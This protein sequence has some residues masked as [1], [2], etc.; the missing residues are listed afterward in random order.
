MKYL[1]GI[2]ESDPVAGV[3]AALERFERRCNVI[4]T[5]HDCCGTFCFP[6]GKSFFP[7]R[8]I[9]RHDYCIRGRFE[10]SGWNR[11]CHEDC[12]LGADAIARRSG[13]P[14]FHS[15]WKGCSEV[16]VPLRQ[17]GNP[18]LI[19]YAG[20]F[21]SEEVSP[22]EELPAELLELHGTLPV[23]DGEFREELAAELQLLGQGMLAL[24]GSLAPHSG[25][26]DY[27]RPE[28]IR[29]FITRHAHEEISLRE[30]A[31]F[32]HLSET[33][34]C[35]QVKYHFGVP[36]QR[37]LVEERMRRARNLLANTDKPLKMIALDTGLRN[38]FYFSRIF[39]RENGMP[40][41]RY[42]EEARARASSGAG[43]SGRPTAPPAL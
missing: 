16:V 17:E 23:C 10:R 35:H 15:C 42:R 21:R 11:R 25:V 7:G 8:W 14:F 33:H 32:L 29:F 41:G 12:M 9:H 4:V 13:R 37:L 43:V 5:I 28:H 18:V 26:P 3:L 39:R 30:L 31:D 36:F 6:D 24:L 19:L 22:P 1:K 38:E 27:S 2:R 20:V 40:P 34:C